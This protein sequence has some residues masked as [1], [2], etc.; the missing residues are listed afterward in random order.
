MY[1]SNIA[2]QP[3]HNL[4]LHNTTQHM[5]MLQK[6]LLMSGKAQWSCKKFSMILQQN[7]FGELKIPEVQTSENR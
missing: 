6:D 4:S 2:P 7:I 1:T 5:H 3:I